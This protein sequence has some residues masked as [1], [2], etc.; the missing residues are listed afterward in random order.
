MPAR[1][2]ESAPHGDQTAVEEEGNEDQR[3]RLSDRTKDSMSTKLH[4]VTAADGPAI[5]FFMTVGEVSDYLGAAAPLD[6]LPRAEW[7]LADWVYD[8]DL[9]RDVLRDKGLK[10]CI[11]GRKSR[12]KVIK[13]DKRRRRPLAADCHRN[14]VFECD[15]VGSHNLNKLRH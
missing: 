2:S 6:G 12:G 10:P 1:G 14:V 11:S 3:D 9:F 7:P 5:R 8:A 15:F 13:H 4:S